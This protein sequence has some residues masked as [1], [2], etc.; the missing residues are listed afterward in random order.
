MERGLDWIFAVVRDD[1][2]MECV[3]ALGQ[4]GVFLDASTRI[5]TPVA[6]GSPSAGIEQA[7][8]LFLQPITV[9]HRLGRIIIADTILDAQGVVAPTYVGRPLATVIER[10]GTIADIDAA[11]VGFEGRRGDSI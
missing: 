5:R 8:A 1:T 9:E 2:Q 4:V 11:N 7:R 6:L 3:T 10:V